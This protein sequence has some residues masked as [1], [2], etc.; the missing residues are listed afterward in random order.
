[1]ISPTPVPLATLEEPTRLILESY[2][3]WFGRDLVA[4]DAPAHGAA[5]LFEAP[6]VVLASRGHPG[7]DSVFCYANRAA[8]ELFETPWEQIVGMPS[9]RSAEAEHRA[10]R[11]L[12][13]DEVDR[14]GFIENYSGIRVS[15]TGR[16]FRILRAKVFN[17]LDR[18]GVYAGQAA[19]FADWEPVK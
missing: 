8:L 19:V 9:S 18:A 16:R 5:A 13:L 4:A 1:M 14:N 17:L 12:L 2:R 6:F 7:A 10:E 11:R 15:R 3:R